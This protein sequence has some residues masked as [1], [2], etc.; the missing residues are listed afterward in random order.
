[1]KY[2]YV[3]IEREYGS[4]G[5]RIGELLSEMSGLPC[6]GRSILEQV[7]ER[8]QIP[9][10]QI[11]QY[12][13]KAT[14]SFLYS[15]YCMG[16]LTTG[17]NDYLSDEAKIYLE[18]QEVI[19]SIVAQGPAIFIGRC[20]SNAVNERDDALHVFIHADKSVRRERAVREYGIL[21]EQVDNVI[22]K[23][24]KKRSNYYS[25]FTGKKWRDYQNYEMVLDSG[26][27]GIENCAGMIWDL[28][29]RQ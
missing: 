1:M 24:D 19:R 6:Y 9:V 5:T 8:L 14:N 4:A 20:A 13:E 18:E 3:V 7:S 15:V 27:L 28:M 25:E 10:A 26:R 29:N 12:E 21:P 11:E 2:K 16:K 17:V 23:F 22:H